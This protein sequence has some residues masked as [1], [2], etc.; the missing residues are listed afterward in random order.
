MTEPDSVAAN[1]IPP[2]IHAGGTQLTVAPAAALLPAPLFVP[3][4]RAAQ[5]FAESFTAQINNDHTRRS[6]LNA[7]RRFSRWCEVRGLAQ[8]TD[9]QP[10]HVAAFVKEMQGQLARPR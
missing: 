9:V 3:T 10:Y 7:T 4:P 8:L 2:R 6:Y 1:P 5:R